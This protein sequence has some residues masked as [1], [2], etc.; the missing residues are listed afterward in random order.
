MAMPASA[1]ALEG[2]PVPE[3]RRK[4]GS[5][6]KRPASTGSRIR[7]G[8]NPVRAAASPRRTEQHARHRLAQPILGW[9]PW[10]DTDFGRS[11]HRG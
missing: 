5:P 2:S 11:S 9:G 6:W 4:P 7:A 8:L 3:D 1:S 10:I